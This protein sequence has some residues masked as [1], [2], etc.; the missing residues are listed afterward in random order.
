MYLVENESITVQLLFSLIKGNY[1]IKIRYG[2]SINLK[3]FF[4]CC[5]AK[6]GRVFYF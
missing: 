5:N 3:T 1:S 6:L 4:L 2:V